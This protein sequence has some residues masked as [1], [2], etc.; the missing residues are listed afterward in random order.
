MRLKKILAILLT[1]V[2]LVSST[3]IALPVSAD[4]D[5]T[6]AWEYK[7]GTL[8][9]EGTS[10]NPYKI[11]NAQDLATLAYLV[12]TGANVFENKYVKQTADIDLDN[13]PWPGIGLNYDAN[14]TATYAFKGHYNGDN[15]AIKNLK[16]DNTYA[17]DRISFGLF[18]FVGFAQGGCKIENINIVSGDITVDSEQY[19]GALIG[20]VRNG[21]TVSNCS[22]MVPVTVT[23]AVD[24]GAYGGLLG[25]IEGTTWSLGY[26]KITNSYNGANVNVSSTANG[27]I[28]VGG[29]CARA[30]VVDNTDVTITMENC[31]NFGDV[32]AT[33]SANTKYY[34]GGVVGRI[35]KLTTSQTGNV[36]I[37]G[38]A[39]LGNITLT[40]AS[41]SSRFGGVMGQLGAGAM[42]AVVADCYDSSVLTVRGYSSE[43]WNMGLIG[44]ISNS[45]IID[46]NTTKNNYSTNTAYWFKDAAATIDT[47][48]PDKTWSS[49]QVGQD[50]STDKVVTNSITKSA[51]KK[52]LDLSALSL[53]SVRGAQYKTD[54]DLGL[55]VRFVGELNLESFAGIKDVG[56]CV[57]WGEKTVNV[58]GS[59]KLYSS[60]NQMAPDGV[61]TPEGVGYLLAAG[62]SGVPQN[63]EITLS[64]KPYVEFEDG[65]IAYGAEA[66]EITFNNG[67]Y[68]APQA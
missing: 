49:K 13:I 6:P 65:T 8:S 44:E 42:G 23:S 4:G 48:T 2:L 62:V 32:S 51:N 31:L 61:I 46:S 63:A 58:S 43:Y 39:N 64:F 30:L 12:N 52:E 5:T 7:T 20:R 41:T 35:E 60:L 36:K 37:K 40:S 15:F 26:V 1:A 38:A 19:V 56:V 59:H 17:S 18:G 53:L 66:T 21:V 3:V 14:G 50:N 24:A 27:N 34:E 68:V 47:A 29:I 9:G 22:N 10:Q 55:C 11:N 54:D 25:R 16:I 57:I 28:T 45:V 33:G 67:A